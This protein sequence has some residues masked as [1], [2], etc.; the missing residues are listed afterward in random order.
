MKSKYLQSRIGIGLVLCTLTLLYRCNSSGSPEQSIPAKVDKDVTEAAAF[1]NFPKPKVLL[2]GTF[3]FDYPG[4]DAFEANENDKIDILSDERQSQVAE[5]ADYILKFKPNKIAIE[6]T[7]E[8]EPTQK[9]R[10][11][12]EGAFR[13]LRDERFQLGMRM[14]ADL[15]MDTI[16]AVDAPTF[17]SELRKD[18]P[19]LM[20]EIWQDFDWKGDTYVDSLY[21]SWYTYSSQ[22]SKRVPLLEYFKYIN[23]SESLSYTYGANLIGDFKLNEYTGAD[24]MSIYWFNRNLRTLR[25]IQSMTESKDDRILILMGSGHIALLSHFLRTSP[26]YEVIEFNSLSKKDLNI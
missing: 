18:R 5:L 19:E 25:K 7:D 16:Y 9:L 2:V 20:Q 15:K 1:F 14:A 4:L 23:S 10:Q 17:D 24:V 12:I 3:H 13:D 26:E 6:A 21:E 11:Y 8:W 22:V